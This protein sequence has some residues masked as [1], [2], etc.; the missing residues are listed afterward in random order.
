MAV[1][2]SSEGRKNCC[3]RDVAFEVDPDGD[4]GDGVADLGVFGDEIEFGGFYRAGAVVEGFGAEVG[5]GP[6][7]G[8]V[9]AAA[10]EAEGEEAL[11]L[12]GVDD[13]E[14]V[15]AG[16]EDLEDA[17]FVLEELGVGRQKLCAHLCLRAGFDEVDG[18][19]LGG[20]LLDD[21]LVEIPLEV[22][23][24]GPEVCAG[25]IHLAEHFVEVA[26][27]WL[28]GGC[29]LREDEGCGQKNEV[30]RGRWMVM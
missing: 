11:I 15:G 19:V 29:A 6:G 21:T 13:G 4:V 23:L 14:V 9:G 18:A 22:G 26:G 17:V 10:A 7:F 8:E 1:F 5:D 25:C 28:G 24:G 30:A 3:L 16:I 2:W 27:L 12:R 20:G